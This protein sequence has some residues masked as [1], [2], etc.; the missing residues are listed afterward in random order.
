MKNDFHG[1]MPTT[2]NHASVEPN[3]IHRPQKCQIFMGFEI[4]LRHLALLSTER[5]LKENFLW[6]G[7]FNRQ[8]QELQYVFKIEVLKYV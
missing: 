2:G 3:F 1:A 5:K 4:T 7:Q 6:I 8:S